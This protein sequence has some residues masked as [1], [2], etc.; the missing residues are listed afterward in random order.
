[1]TAFSC[2]LPS[3]PTLQTSFS[4][5]ST[6]PHYGHLRAEQ[7]QDA[8]CH[9]GAEDSSVWLLNKQ[10]IVRHGSHLTF[11]LEPTQLL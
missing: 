8:A 9:H 4:G 3:A 1:M 5:Q 6:A 7:W 10:A 2:A 11:T